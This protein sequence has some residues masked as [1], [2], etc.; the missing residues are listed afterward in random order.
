MEVIEQELDAIDEQIGQGANTPISQQLG[1]IE[2]NCE[3]FT[4]ENCNDTLLRLN[5]LIED[6]ENGTRERRGGQLDPESQSDLRN[7]MEQNIEFSQ[8][9]KFQEII[10]DIEQNY[11][12]FE[13]YFQLLNKSKQYNGSIR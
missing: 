6:M 8:I 13:E 5:V 9:Q 12:T 10:D 3:I 1:D 2:K 4:I 11:S 7:L